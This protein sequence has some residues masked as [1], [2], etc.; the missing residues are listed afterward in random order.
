MSDS[1][2]GKRIA[3][4]TLMLYFRQILIML[5]SLYTVRVVLDVLG[6]EDYGIYN[7]VAGVVLMFSFLSNAMATASQRYFS[8]DLGKNDYEKLKKTFSVSF[9][10]YLIIIIFIVLLAE[11]VG[12]WFLYTQID[13]P[14][15][16]FF[17]ATIVYQTAIFAFICSVFTTPYMAA[18]LSHED[19]NIYAYVSF[20]EVFLKLFIVFLLKLFDKDK[21]IMFGIL[22][23]I[24]VFITTGTYRIISRKKYVECRAPLYW[25]YTLFKEMMAYSIWNFYS[26]MSYIIKNHA[27]TIL[28]NNFYSPV[29]VT[30][31]AISIQVSNA[32][33]TLSSNFS[34]AVKPTITKVYAVE[35]YS[36]LF[37]I[38]CTS[39]KMIYFLSLLFTVPLLFHIKYIL[40]VWLKTYPVETLLFTQL[41]LIANLIDSIGQ[42][43]AASNQATG[44]VRNYLLFLGSAFIL[45]IPASYILLRSGFS[46]YS[47]YICDIVAMIVA[48]I[49]RLLFTRR[50]TGFS[51]AKFI[52]KVVA[53]IVIVTIIVFFINSLFTRYFYIDSLVDFIF[54]FCFTVMSVVI[55]G[56]LLGLNKTQ[57]NMVIIFIRNKIYGYK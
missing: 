28:L 40:D 50:I 16:R 7:V 42:P 25:N 32:I 12:L 4:N 31:R 21:L 34:I 51:I 53:P 9:I 22:H 5:V 48:L 18:I 49:I 27:L 30:A 17:A 37:G 56:Y 14:S 46:I 54:S 26:H 2:T 39:C 20:V 1:S 8:Y 35:E 3:R 11:T 52:I 38:V 41:V 23:S 57:K 15:E 10:S 36:K 47:I 33:K 45:V 29:I 13:I 19:M 55:I 44:K 6:A 43:L 24:A